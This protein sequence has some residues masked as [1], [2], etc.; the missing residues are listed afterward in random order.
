M[1]HIDHY[2]K[3]IKKAIRYIKQDAP[4]EQLDQIKEL[5]NNAIEKRTRVDK[6]TS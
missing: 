4:Q 1:K 6:K 2:P 3:A 5:F